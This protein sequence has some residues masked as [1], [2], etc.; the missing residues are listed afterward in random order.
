[1]AEGRLFLLTDK[2]MEGIMG[3]DIRVMTYNIHFTIGTD[4]VADWRRTAAM[5]RAHRPDVVGLQEVTIFHQGSPDVDVPRALSRELDMDIFFGRTLFYKSGRGEYGIA[6]MARDNFTV[7]EKIVLATPEGIEPRTAVI[8]KVH[9]E[10]PYYFVVT[11]FSYQG[12]FEGDEMYRTLNAKLITDTVVDKNYFPAIWVGDFNTFE[13]TSTLEYI[14][15]HW[16]VANDLDPDTPSCETGKFGL[17]QIDF[18]CTYPKNAFAVQDFK[19]VGD[20]LVSDHSPVIA[21]LSRN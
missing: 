20:H 6:A 8:I 19:V 1:M 18:I 12:E 3:Q 15:K 5:I 10:Q 9:A 17:R 21:T 2:T 4:K 13:G 11:H 14:H 16:Q 7:M